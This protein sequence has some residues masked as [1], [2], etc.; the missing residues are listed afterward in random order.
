MSI[1]II[2]TRRFWL[3]LLILLLI[4]AFFILRSTS[5]QVVL[6]NLTPP[7]LRTPTPT[8]NR[9]VFE[10]NWS[11][12]TTDRFHF[13]SQGTGTLP[14]PYDWLLALEQPEASP[15][16]LLIPG[17]K[18]AFV[19]PAYLESYGFIP[20]MAS[21]ENPDALPI[22]FA[23][24]PFQNL[25]GYSTT[26]TS[27]GFTCAA[28]HTG[29]ISYEGTEYIVNGGPSTVD[30]QLFSK[31]LGAAIG[32]TLMSS[33]LPLPNKRFDRFARNVLGEAYSKTAKSK[34]ATELSNVVD[35]GAA[36][37]DQITVVEGFGRLDALNRIGN[38]VFSKN[39]GRRQNYMPINAPVNY[40]QIWTASWFDWVQYD[41]SIMQP[42]IRNAGEALGVHAAVNLTA[43]DG[44]G[45][46]TSS[47]PVKN[48]KW[49][50]DSL[51][52]AEPPLQDRAFG[53]LHAPQWPEAFGKINQKLA[54]Q[55]AVIYKQRCQGCHLPPLSSD[56]IWDDKYF[57]RIAYEENGVTK[58]TTEAFLALNILPLKTIGTDPAQSDILLKRTIN[59]AGDVD[60]GAKGLGIDAT[61]CTPEPTFTG[62]SPRNAGAELDTKVT[63]RYRETENPLIQVQ[64]S[65]GPM[66]NFALALGAIVQQTDDAWFDTNFISEE[67]RAY[68]E[69]ERPNCLQSGAGYKA[70][71]LNGV[72]ATG[73]FLHNGSVPTLDA[74]LRPAHE[75]PRFVRLG[76]TAFD[77]VKVGL[78][79]PDLS[80]DSYPAYADGYFYLDTS[81][82]GNRNTG[83]AFGAA[84]DGNKHGV[85]GPA[86]SEAQRMAIIEYLKTLN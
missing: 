46:F 75:R 37:A 80:E 27:V 62:S 34:L 28:C 26:T 17:S 1:T 2:F 21:L 61:V 29:R 45:R 86:F 84:A 60:T 38:Q 65:D 40:P 64:V 49:I 63:Q 78:A 51:A 57:Q 22:G 47:I 72:W 70:R 79:Q 20:Q 41:G 14:I 31:G 8:E 52:G 6:E 68:F 74:L 24:T 83:H 66:V 23:T 7:E 59:T 30:L 44:Q 4:A 54:D 12:A 71:P 73:P 77:P 9:I 81:L 42:L 43:P 15:F 53:G 58:E 50:E 36:Q 67:M 69:G 25:A 39:T 85:I 3:A 35:A 11:D 76:D 19:T 56:A 18:D 5:V 48:L 16:G 82:P 13:I 10:Q 55:G 33:K 32:Q